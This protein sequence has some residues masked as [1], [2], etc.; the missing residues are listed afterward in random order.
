M[1]PNVPPAQRA[2]DMT[3]RVIRL[4][5][6]RTTTNMLSSEASGSVKKEQQL[7]VVL[8]PKTNKEVVVPVIG[9]PRQFEVSDMRNVEGYLSSDKTK[10]Y[11]QPALGN[12]SADA[13]DFL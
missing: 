10:V 8:S 11:F 6:G 9:T 1:D 4:E 12:A 13:S 5:G 7:A 2:P 3:L